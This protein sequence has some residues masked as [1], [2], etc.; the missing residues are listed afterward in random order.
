VRLAIHGSEVPDCAY[1]PFFG[2]FGTAWD[3]GMVATGVSTRSDTLAGDGCCDRE[4]RRQ[5]RAAGHAA[6]AGGLAAGS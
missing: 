1:V 2:A 3:G 4:L 5:W 6:P